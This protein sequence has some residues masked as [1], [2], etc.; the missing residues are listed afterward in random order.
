MEAFEVNMMEREL[1]GK[2]MIRKIKVEGFVPGIIY[3]STGN[4][5]VALEEHTLDGILNKHGDDVTLKIVHNGETIMTQVKEVQRD[6][7]TREMQ[8][9]DLMPVEGAESISRQIH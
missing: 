5:P 4:I 7:V 8:H 3:S 2:G 1:A 9:I 6:P